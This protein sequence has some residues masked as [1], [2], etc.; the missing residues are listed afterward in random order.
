MFMDTNYYAENG[1]SLTESAIVNNIDIGDEWREIV[2]LESVQNCCVTDLSMSANS[3]GTF[4]IALNGFVLKE[5]YYRAKD[6]IPISR[7]LPFYIPSGMP[8]KIE[9]KTEAD[10]ASASACIAGYLL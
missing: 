6:Y 2:V 10:D 5:I 1:Y 9:F 3:N 7:N 4:R 8:I